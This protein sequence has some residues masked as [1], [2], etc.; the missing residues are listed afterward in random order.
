MKNIFPLVIHDMIDTKIN[1]FISC[2]SSCCKDQDLLLNI[3]Q[4]DVQ[5][6]NTERLMFIYLSVHLSLWLCASPPLFSLQPLLIN[7]FRLQIS[8]LSHEINCF[9]CQISLVWPQLN[10]LRPW[11]SCTRALSGL[12]SAFFF[13]KSTVLDL[14]FCLLSPNQPSQAFWSL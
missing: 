11:I 13:L 14:K 2:C 1:W 12:K 10:P 7:S 9:G 3:V 6:K 8:I 5:Q 4:F